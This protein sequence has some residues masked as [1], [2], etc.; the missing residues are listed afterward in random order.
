[1][2]EEIARG[3]VLQRLGGVGLIIGGILTL[4]FNA[5]APRVDDPSDVAQVLA[6]AAANE[7][8]LTVVLLG[9]AVGIWALM[10]GVVG[11][12]RSIAAGGAAAW[13][14]LGFY[15][16]IVGT[17]LFTAAFAVNIMGVD[18]SVDWAAAG[19]AVGT[20]TYT[21][22]ATLTAVAQ[23]LFN[24]T[25]VVLWLA[26]TFLAIG[27]VLS[28]VY[29]RWQGWWLLIVA[30]L[31]TGVGI[32]TLLSEPSQALELAF[33]VPAALTSVWAA[34]VGVWVARRAW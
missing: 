5:V 9:L 7:R 33:A 24:M 15:G 10:I 3:D 1:M 4:V 21:I 16:T 28:A 12:Y 23:S 30:A 11:L 6:S 14:R 18:A 8:L 2:R 27:M 20:P 13:A 22:A 32:V 19:S 25:I 31:V 29:P 34:V 17:T 26:L